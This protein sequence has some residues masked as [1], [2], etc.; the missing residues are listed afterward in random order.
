MAVT[1]R[2]RRALRLAASA[3]SSAAPMWAGVRTITVREPVAATTPL[4]PPERRATGWASPPSTGSNQTTPSSSSGFA[5][6]VPGTARFE[7]NRK[8]PSAV[9]APK[10]SPSSERVRRRA[11]RWPSGSS[12][13]H[14]DRWPVRSRF[15]WATD[16]S[17]RP[18][19][20][21]ASEPSLG[22]LV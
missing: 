17:T 10:L 2:S 16:T 13:H 20:E 12:S 11:G 1:L 7:P 8:S 3:S 19:G 6:S 9:K 22:R 14:D 18:C 5:S 15:R 4:N 21:I